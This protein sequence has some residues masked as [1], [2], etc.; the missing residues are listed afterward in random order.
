M[1]LAHVETA[2]KS[3]A[4]DDLSK[5]APLQ[6]RAQGMHQV[7]LERSD[8]PVRG[9]PRDDLEEIK[10]PG[11]LVEEMQNCIAVLVAELDRDVHRVFP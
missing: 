8:R 2:C 4:L 7:G 11:M 6:L 3:S 10:L 5:T 9:N 1:L